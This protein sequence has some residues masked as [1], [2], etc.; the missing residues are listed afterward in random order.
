LNDA[1]SSRT[2]PSQGGAA[3]P[4]AGIDVDAAMTWPVEIRD[5][6]ERIANEVRGRSR[7]VNDVEAL[8]NLAEELRGLFVGRL[9]RAYHATRLLDHE[10]TMIRRQGLRVLEEALILQRIEEV[11]R[12]GHLSGAE[13]DQLVSGNVFSE[14][15]SHGRAG[16]VSLFLSRTPLDRRVSGVWSLLTTWGGEGI[17]MAHG[18]HALREKLGELGTPTIVVVDVD[19]GPDPEI[20]GI[21]PELWKLYVGR[22]LGR[23]PQ[24]ADLFYKSPVPPECIAEFWQPGD[25]AWDAYRQL[26]RT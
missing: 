16:H 23:E 7:Y 22:L 19:L 18:G 21:Y 6:A 9:L 1:I 12:R 2:R 14:G 26:P 4:K 25:A 15:K 24:G 8:P 5:A 20:H 11:S 13:R 10:I 3:S 17:Y